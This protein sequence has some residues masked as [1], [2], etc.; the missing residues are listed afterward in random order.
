M[1]FSRIIY[2][3]IVIGLVA[4]MLLT[5]LQIAGLK[6][7]IVEAERFEAS[8]VEAPAG[9]GNSAHEH[10]GHEH[11][12]D[13]H[14]DAGYIYDIWALTQG[15]ERAA[16]SFLANALASAGF[17]A[18]ML[19]LMN[20]FQLARKDEI[21]WG[22]GSLWG[23][24]GFATLFLAPAIGL[25]PEIPGAVSAALEHRQLWWALAVF[26]VAI[27]LGI[28]AFAGVRFKALGVLFLMIPYIVG[29][30][31]VDLPMFQHAD[32]S[33]TQALINLHQQFVVISTVVNLIFWLSLGLC[34]RFAFNRW[35]RGLA[36]S[37][38]PDCS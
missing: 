37:A 9:H 38:D 6:Q 7:I 5:S 35:F 25:P 29:A 20:Q 11:S 2:S 18:I 4:G 28:F 3:S 21:S 34:C 31:Q 26:S 32:P 27:G 13:G 33:V 17:A 24:A 8:A 10:S 19:A 16:Y 14:A 1:I 15:L 36:A 30:P 12:D 22:Q 23:L